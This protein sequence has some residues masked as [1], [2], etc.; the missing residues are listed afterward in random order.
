M[1]DSQ[2]SD[3][4]R[5]S[6]QAVQRGR[7]GEEHRLH[8]MWTLSDGNCLLHASLL[9]IW[10]VHDRQ[11]VGGLSSLRAAMCKLLAAP[12]LS[13]PLRERFIAENG[14]QNSADWVPFVW[15]E[16]QEEAEW[17]R[18][19]QEARTQNTFLRPVHVLSMACVLK[20]PIVLYSDTVTRDA[21]NLPI[22]QVPFYGIYLP[23]VVPPEQCSKQPLVLVFDSAHFMPLV[24][25]A[26]ADGGTV[27]IPL[28]DKDY[29]PL[30]LRFRLNDEEVAGEKRDQLLSSYMNM[31]VIPK[32]SHDWEKELPCANLEREGTNELVQTMLD[33]FVAAAEHQFK[34]V[35]PDADGSGSGIERQ[36]SPRSQSEADRML[37]EQ[38]GNEA[39]ATNAHDDQQLAERLQA[40]AFGGGAANGAQSDADAALARQL[41]AELN[42]GSQQPGASGGSG[43]GSVSLLFRFKV[44]TEHIANAGQITT[45]RSPEFG[46]LL[47]SA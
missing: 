8:L 47:R 17:Q 36:M 7:L 28:V 18:V 13:A 20:R 34:V 23:F 33:Q 39:V 41:Q 45:V 12:S 27:H 44:T 31:T 29:E 16:D 38:L 25:S 42:P 9:G 37:A 5:V 11:T 32:G 30:P 10:G 46:A 26:R 4:A 14:R 1:R 40:E 22:A 6:P 15:D 43:A 21:F 35:G 24:A 3:T 19:L 2:A